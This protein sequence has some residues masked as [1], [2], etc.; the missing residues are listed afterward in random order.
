MLCTWKKIDVEKK[1]D[2]QSE[3]SYRVLSTSTCDQLVV[4]LDKH[5][6]YEAISCVDNNHKMQ[7]IV[8]S[9][10]R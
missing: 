10:N 4:S 1:G 5:N 9:K 3:A 6:S 7:E 2:G 8:K